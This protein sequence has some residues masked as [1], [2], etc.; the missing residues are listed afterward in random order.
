MSDLITNKPATLPLDERKP[1]LAPW[2]YDVERLIERWQEGRS[3]HTVRAYG[4]DLGHFAGWSEAATP[5]EAI[6]RLLTASM[7]EAN[8]RLYAYRGAM[9]DT[10]LAPATVNRRLSALRSIVQLGRTFGLITWSLEVDGVKSRAY[11]D[12]AGPGLDGVTAVKRQAARHKSPAKAARDVAIVRILFDLA[13]RRSE[14]AG[15]DL[16]HVDIRA[17]RLWVLG[18]GR[19]ERE[20]MTMPPRTLNALK[21][22][23]K[24][25]G[26]QPGP[27]F[28]N[29]HPANKGGLDRLE[30]NGIYWVVRS[31][32]TQVDITVRPHG[33]RHSS[34]TTGL[35][36]VKDP[37]KVQKHGR[38]P[39]PAKCNAHLFEGGDPV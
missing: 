2:A 28:T 25:R 13:L 26:K 18:K 20:A 33:L 21:A 8:E 5:G 35:E 1:G 38:H 17:N 3:P 30:A 36:R 23:L 6:N 22:W 9:L 7:G 14:V 32:G 37:R 10:G 11:R 39:P 4:R 29:F 12:T 27:L 19:K 24:H 31:L 34:I 15:L 16:E